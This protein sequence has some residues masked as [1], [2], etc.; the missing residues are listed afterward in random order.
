MKV[1]LFVGIA[2]LGLYASG[3]YGKAECYISN[4]PMIQ[5]GII[6]TYA[7]SCYYSEDDGSPF[8]L[9]TA[10]DLCKG[11]S[12]TSNGITTTTANGTVTGSFPSGG[13]TVTCTCKRGTTTYKCASGYYGTATSASAGCTACPENA[14]CSGG[15][16]STFM[17]L[18]GYYKNGWT[19]SQC[20]DR[21]YSPDGATAITECR[22]ISGTPFSDE[23]GSGSYTADCYYQQ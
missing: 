2:T 16:N 17:C 4:Q 22:I 15:N 14:A 13:G 21:Q 7:D 5:D 9:M 12:S 23:T 11:G 8:Q 18:A 3:A 20:P 19:C 6:Y 10:C 1:F